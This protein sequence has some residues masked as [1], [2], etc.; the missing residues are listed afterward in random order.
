MP[1]T[2]HVQMF[3]YGTVE[4]PQGDFEVTP[5]FARKLGEAVKFYA[6]R[7]YFSPILKQHEENGFVYGRVIRIT[8][9]EEGVYADVEV[10]EMIA[11]AIDEG[12]IDSWSP[13]F[14][15][16]WKD[17]HTDE[18]FPVALRELSFVSVRHLKNLPGQSPYYSLSDADWKS[19]AE[20]QGELNME[21]LMVMLEAFGA[22]LEE[23]KA[24]VQLIKEGLTPDEE[25]EQEEE[26]SN[27]PDPQAEMSEKIEMLEKQ[28]AEYQD[29]ELEESIKK[30][31]SEEVE[32]STLVVLKSL[33][34]D[35]RKT[36]I[37][38]INTASQKAPAKRELGE[39]G[40]PGTPAPEAKATT[41][42]SL[43]EQAKAEG[44]GRGGELINYLHKRGFKG[45][46]D[47]KVAAE[48]FEK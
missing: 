23:L 15:E 27:E 30:E 42:R 13:S 21:E 24:D 8:S 40:T 22:A 7:K 26:S 16:N 20:L 12:Y 38:T 37:T 6:K 33:S 29:K 3:K 19:L 4:H 1:V 5:E 36:M 2:K 35:A 34:E 10:P 45:E 47:V 25:P 46:Y 48:V 44:I 14:Y 11:E 41:L 32:E 17:P 43:C 39:V 9:N 28:L 18:V 31:L